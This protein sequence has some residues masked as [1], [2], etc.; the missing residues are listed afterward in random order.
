MSRKE[1]YKR[2]KHRRLYRDGVK[3]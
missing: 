2:W 1:L 3:K